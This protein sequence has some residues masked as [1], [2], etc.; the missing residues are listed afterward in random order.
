MYSAG[1]ILLSLT[2]LTSWTLTQIYNPVEDERFPVI[3]KTH[4]HFPQNVVFVIGS[5][6]AA[7]CFSLSAD[8]VSHT[9]EKEAKT[10]ETLY[11]KRPFPLIGSQI[12]IKTT[13]FIMGGLG[14]FWY[15]LLAIYSLDT[16]HTEHWYVA[17]F[18][19]LSAA[20]EMVFLYLVSDIHNYF[21]SNEIPLG[22]SSLLYVHLRPAVSKKSLNWKLGCIVVSASSILGYLYLR[23]Y[24][25]R[26]TRHCDWY[27]ICQY[28]SV[29]AIIAYRSSYRWDFLK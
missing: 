17:G 6:I 8:K 24:C 23:F 16:A 27:A 14:N 11:G 18:F 29:F 28:L 2:L 13:L 19:A 26:L 5:T 10:I 20:I 21:I 1:P 12:F 7:V 4:L 3:S 15:P 22:G 9:I 25:L